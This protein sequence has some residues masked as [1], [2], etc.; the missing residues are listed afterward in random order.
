MTSTPS[1]PAATPPSLSPAGRWLSWRPPEWDESDRQAV[2]DELFFEGPEWRPF[3]WRFGTLIVLSTTIAGLG[4]VANS[5]AV[6]IGAMLVAPL[7]TPILAVAAAA[8]HGQTRR[9]GVST[10][11]LVGGTLAA[12]ATGWL[13]GAAAPGTITVDELTSELLARTSPSLLDLGVAVA[14]GLAGGYVLTH[15][16]AGSSLPGVAIAV[17]LVPPLATVGITLQIGAI[18][19]TRGALLLYTTNLVAIILSAMVMML[20]SG[21]VPADVR[22]LAR[23]RVRT[24]LVVATIAVAAVALPLSA[25]TLEVIADQRF[26]R[27][28]IEAAERW[29]PSG[30][31]VSITADAQADRAVVDIV[32]ASP[33]AAQPAWRLAEDLAALIGT[34]VDVTVEYRLEQRDEAT[35][36]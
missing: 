9:L 20:L 4:L 34:P 28:V 15:P 31:V 35:A 24:G 7:M 25:H 27:Q 14:A 16:R 5:S 11:V 33:R 10:A 18:D 19:Q 2:L 32:V 12:V 8:V 17:A 21:F 26:N 13:V 36:G 1:T 3:L 22:H 23:G 30:R 6:V 29:D